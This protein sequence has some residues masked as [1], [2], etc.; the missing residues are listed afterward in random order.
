MQEVLREFAANLF[1]KAYQ[2]QRQGDLANAV[3]LYKQSIKTFPTAEAHTF[4]GW[5]YHG[6]GKLD[7]AFE[8]CLAA[9]EVDP[10]FGH[11]YNDIGAYL[12][13]KG[14]LRESIPWLEK[15]TQ[16][17]RFENYHFPWY[18][19]GRVYFSLEMLNMAKECFERAIKLKSDFALANDALR[20]L[21]SILQ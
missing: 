18:N 4:L 7:L 11:P 12:I 13:E 16:A 2:L 21:R 20:R 3:I 15:A 8:E 19:L 14:K 17:A 6:Q 10:S 1:Q 9:I 5:T